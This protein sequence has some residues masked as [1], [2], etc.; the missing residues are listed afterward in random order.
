MCFIHFSSPVTIYLK[1]WSISL[2]FSSDSLMKI[3]SNKIFIHSSCGI[4]TIIFFVHPA[5]WLKPSFDL[6]LVLLTAYIPVCRNNLPGFIA[7][8]SDGSNGVV[9]FISSYKI[10]SNDLVVESKS[11][12]FF[13]WATHRLYLFRNKFLKYSKVRLELH[14][15]SK[16]KILQMKTVF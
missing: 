9:I 1:N 11:H 3:R 2:R 5:K 6:R 4:Q 12:E 14:T 8:F 15:F 7:F 16:C 10:F 13:S